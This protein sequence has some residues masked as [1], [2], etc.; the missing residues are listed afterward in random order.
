M[1][2]TFFQLMAMSTITVTK[3]TARG[4]RITTPYLKMKE[5][6]ERILEIRNSVVVI[7]RNTR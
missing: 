6:A 4:K 5:N 3:Y 2:S 7:A 1:F